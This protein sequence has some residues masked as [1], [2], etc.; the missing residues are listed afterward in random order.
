MTKALKQQC[1]STEGNQLVV[2]IR[3]ESH[4]DQ[5]TMLQ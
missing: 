5:S 4:Q 2:K 3:H 1:Q